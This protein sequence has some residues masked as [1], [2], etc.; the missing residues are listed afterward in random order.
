MRREPAR[1]AHP[2]SSITQNSAT[3][4]AIAGNDVAEKFID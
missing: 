3:A 2:P 1:T 4:S